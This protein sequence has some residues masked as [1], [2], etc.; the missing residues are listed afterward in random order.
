[1]RLLDFFRA[2]RPAQSAAGAAKERL[3]IVVAHDRV[4]TNR[5]DI[6]PTLQREIMK[7][8]ARYCDIDE[9]LLSINVE[10]NGASSMLEINVEL[11]NDRLMAAGGKR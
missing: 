10:R 3:Q 6:L 7:V 11:P 4:G 1:M 8:V 5:P 2:S 9:K